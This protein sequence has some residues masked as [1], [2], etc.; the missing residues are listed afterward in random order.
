MLPPQREHRFTPNRYE[1]K[2]AKKYAQQPITYG[3]M[4]KSLRNKVTNEIR[5][6]KCKYFNDKLMECSADAGRTWKVINSVLNRGNK[7]SMTKEILT[8]NE[9]LVE[10]K[11]IAEKFN[12]YFTNIGSNL[13]EK[14]PAS[15]VHYSHFLRNRS[16]VE[17][18]FN[19]INSNELISIVRKFKDCSPGIDD[20]SMKVLKSS[21]D[22]IKDPLTLICNLSLQNGTVPDQLKISKVT[23]VF[24]SGK[25]NELN[26]YRPIAILPSIGKI[27]EKIFSDQL[28]TYFESNDLFNDYQFGFRG[29]RSAEVALS[30]FVND[31]L[32][33]SENKNYTVSLFLDYSKAFDTVQHNI[34]LHKLE[35]YGV[36]GT[37]LEWINSYLNN[38][39]QCV[40]YKKSLSSLK[41]II[42]SIPQGSSLG[43]LLFIIYINDISYSSN[44]FKYSL[45]ADDSV[46]YASGKDLPL[47]I[48]TVNNELKNVNDWLLANKITLNTKKSH[49]MLFGNKRRTI[50][51]NQLSS[52]KINEI[53]ITK[54]A[55]TDFL[56]VTINEKLEWSQHIRNVS[57][58]ISKLNG[59]LF[60]TRHLLTRETL[61]NIY[62]TLV[63][64]HI[65]Y[66]HTVWGNTY[67]K[68]LKPLIL[69]QKRI[70]RTITF[71]R[72]Y[73]HTAP[74]FQSL[75]I[76]NI[77]QSTILFATLF[78][79]KVLNNL[80]FSNI[81]FDF[82]AN[83]HNINLR[84]PLR[85]RSPR[86]SSV[87]RQHSISVFGCKAWN[88]LSND[89][90]QSSSIV[91]FKRKVREW[92]MSSG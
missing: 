43:P 48:N 21:I 58:Q 53:Q 26:N 1:N 80:V 64:P 42:C 7:K 68:H 12:D 71:S 60:L 81:G 70:V 66:C 63:N 56:G 87:K 28:C 6:S 3:K 83:T 24:K 79:F 84:D 91:I 19:L 72:K 22:I 76:L 4:Y 9:T 38:R 65:T 32:V 13:V 46:L 36:R 8:E 45:Y 54:V 25:L 75:N 16:Q 78:V 20:I 49:Y 39:K 41:D 90:K 40:N 55:D 52:I 47:L 92:L 86:F 17:F 88:N 67:K 61:K 5:K 23:P 31:V 14:L 73:T 82:A 18:G 44:F 27:I 69:T 35:H 11:D 62:L 57:N 51:Y 77:K 30:G 74:L 85:L 15:S 10:N 89:I 34:L 37:A 29:G 2:L 50:Q 33:A 59:I